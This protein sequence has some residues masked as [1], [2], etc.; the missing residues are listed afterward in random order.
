M[1][2]NSLFISFLLVYSLFENVCCSFKEKQ[3]TIQIEL[4]G[5]KIYAETAIFIKKISA[6][7]DNNTSDSI[8]ISPLTVVVKDAVFDEYFECFTTIFRSLDTTKVDYKG[9]RVSILNDDNI[10]ENRSFYGK[11]N[12]DYI[13]NQ[14]ETCGI[15][16]YDSIGANV[17]GA[18]K[19]NRSFYYK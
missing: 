18:I 7:N 16:K 19:K 6:K 11:A 4:L 1:T 13:I 10:I 8:M 12:V 14:L 17:I 9:V 3:N 2:K 5:D 15:S